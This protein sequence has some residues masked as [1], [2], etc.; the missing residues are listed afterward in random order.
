MPYY[1]I[2]YY[3]VSYHVISYHIKLYLLLNHIL[4]CR[5]ATNYFISGMKGQLNMSQP[6]EDL[7]KAIGINQWP[8]RNPFSL[9]KWEGK[10]WP[11]M[12]NLLSEYN[13]MLLR[14]AQLVAWTAELITPY[15]VWLPGLFN[16][17]SYL[18][19]VMQVTARRT[20]M[21]LDQ[22]TT[23][24]HVTTF[25]RPETIDYYPTDGAFI[26]GLY[27]EGARWPTGDETGDTDMVTGTPTAGTTSTLTLA[28]SLSPSPSIY[29][30]LY[31]SISPCVSLS[32]SVCLSL[33]LFLS[34]SATDTLVN[35]PLL[36]ISSLLFLS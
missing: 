6:M 32:L 29:H 20:G 5:V 4:S 14:V 24:T 35:L 23:E 30:Y 27:I 31:L 18:T 17:T 34:F 3:V 12:K 10:A 2:S 8:G 7:I 16:P 26:H 28:L 19:A 15:S 13:D 9:C 33:S 25:M 36:F 21:P 22:M 11:S 1:I